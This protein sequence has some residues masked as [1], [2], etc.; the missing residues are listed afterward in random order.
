MLTLTNPA[1]S[2]GTE[3]HRNHHPTA[4]QCIQE[5]PAA[6]AASAAP[7]RACRA[8][9]RLP[10]LSRA[11]A[12]PDEGWQRRHRPS[13][14]RRRRRRAGIT[15]RFH[16]LTRHHRRVVGCYRVGGLGT[17]PARCGTR[18]RSRCWCARR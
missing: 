7:A 17:E 13:R 16:H 4:T 15:A 2:N 1:A 11:H 9:P 8:C 10:R 3:C 18:R 6:D 14:S 5:G 12:A